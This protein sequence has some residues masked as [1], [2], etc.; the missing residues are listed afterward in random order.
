[1]SGNN[2]EYIQAY[3]EL[4]CLLKYFPKEYI[5]KLP[6]KLLDL[7]EKNTTEEFKIN[8]DYNK[9]LNSLN[10]SEKTY[11]LL[12]VLKY[13]Y[14]STG[15]EKEIIAKK[16]NENEKTFQKELREKYNTDNLFKK[17]EQ[18]IEETIDTNLSM[19][20]YKESILKKIINKL[21]NLF[22]KN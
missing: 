3:T 13:N 5:K 22:N 16:L 19:I 4:N 2:V 10:L 6:V 11:N 14:W 1:M 9:D 12:S 21:R 17:K 18:S 20:Q 8:I 15:E 7:I